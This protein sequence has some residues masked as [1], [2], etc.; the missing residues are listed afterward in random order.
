MIQSQCY[1]IFEILHDYRVFQTNWKRKMRTTNTS[2]IYWKIPTVVRKAMKRAKLD[3][4]HGD[5]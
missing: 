1:E 3:K 2:Q 5:P 4:F